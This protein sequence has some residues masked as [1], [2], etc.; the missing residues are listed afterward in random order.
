[1]QNS[2]TFKIRLE[3]N[4]LSNPERLILW[5]ALVEAQETI[6]KRFTNKIVLVEW[7][8]TNWRDDQK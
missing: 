6:C 2:N 5:N 3:A 4:D 1:M 8:T 7:N